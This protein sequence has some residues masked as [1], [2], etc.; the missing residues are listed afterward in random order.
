MS[1][2]AGGPQIRQLWQEYEDCSSPEAE[3]VK[4]FDKV[5]GGLAAGA[6]G[7]EHWPLKL[8]ACSWR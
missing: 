2:G 7:C 1:L 5:R 4:D 3:L 6:A 8:A